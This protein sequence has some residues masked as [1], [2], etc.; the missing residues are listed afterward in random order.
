MHEG[1]E[2]LNLLPQGSDNISGFEISPFLQLLALLLGSWEDHGQ[3]WS[4]HFKEDAVL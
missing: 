1:K 4:I 3:V 2:T